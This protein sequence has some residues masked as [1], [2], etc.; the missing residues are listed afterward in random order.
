MP[1][2][3]DKAFQDRIDKIHAE[4]NGLRSALNLETLRTDWALGAIEGVTA[5][6]DAYHT[7][8]RQS[9]YLAAFEKAEP[10]VSVCVATV[11]R[12]ALLMER[13][14]PSLLAQTYQNLQ[15]VVVGD[16]CTDDTAQRLAALRDR[17]VSFV[18]LPARGPYPR[19]GLDRWCVA[20]ANAMNHALSLCEGDFVTHL[21]DDDSATA[22][23]IETLVTAAKERRADFLWHPF[24]YETHDGTW[25]RLGNG[26]LEAGQVTTGSIFY[27]RY[28]ARYPWDVHAY[29]LNEPGDWNRLRKIKILRPHLHFV[30]QPL[31]FHHKEQSQPVF[32]A[33]DGEQFLE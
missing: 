22:D 4:L 19:P 16:H 21:D 3:S 31:L 15:I 1:E 10:L 32:V 12:S 23:R 5:D 24:W 8:R 7:I 25:Q 29:R 26:R 11:N 9:D 2:G 14:I 13:A 20:G 27:H 6:I 18:N 28:F 33:Y 17:R 30:D